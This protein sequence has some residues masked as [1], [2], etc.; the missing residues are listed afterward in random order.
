MPYKHRQTLSVF[1]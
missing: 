1:P